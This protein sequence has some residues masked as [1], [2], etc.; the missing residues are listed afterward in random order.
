MRDPVSRAVRAARSDADTRALWAAGA[1]AAFLAMSLTE[2]TFQN[3]QFS[4]LLLLVWAWGTISLR[5]GR[6]NL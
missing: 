3:E 4:T 2:T 1:T 6:E 5:S